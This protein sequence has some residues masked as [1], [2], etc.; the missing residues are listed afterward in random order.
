MN[1]IKHLKCLSAVRSMTAVRQLTPAAYPGVHCPMHTALALAANIRGVSTLLIGT[2][3]CGYYSR[4]VPLSSPYGEEALHWNYVLDSK[5]VVFGFRKGLMEA[6]REMNQAG[7]RLILLLS[8]CVPELI[9]LDLESICLEMQQEVKAVLIHLPFGNFKCGGYEPG[10]WKTLLAMGKT[11]EKAVSKGTTVNVLG[12]S[13]LEGHVPMPHLIAFLKQQG[14]PLRF[15]APDSSLDDFISSGDA[16]LNL[17]LSPFM[18][19]LAQWMAK[20]HDI[21]FVSLHD[22][23]NVREI[24]ST[25]SQIGQYL[26]LEMA[27][28]FAEQKKEGKR[29]QKAA[30]D[31]LKT[32][33]YVSAN[34]GTVQPLP[35]SA[36]LSDLGMSPI[37]I[38][39]AEFY[40][41]DNRWKEMLTGQDI[42]PIICLMLNEQADMQ[43][44]EELRPDLVMG[45]WGGR[46]RN[47]PPSVSVLDLYGHIGYERT[48]GL[49]NRMTRALRIGKEERTNGT[50]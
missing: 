30:A 5:E 7:A 33:Q 6:I 39:M 50:V 31:Q 23:Y 11:I 47:N 1:D 44:I 18:D 28:E 12:R 48:I 21:P 29:A 40:P 10:Y 32:L 4:N 41:S 24:E 43:I 19:P 3:E 42:N 46:S 36:Y 26:D 15:L 34:L 38:H 17:V 14:V 16:R 37:M 49:L 22:V 13:A 8:T 35:L 25:Y 27:H 9:G 45:D 20:E 2:A